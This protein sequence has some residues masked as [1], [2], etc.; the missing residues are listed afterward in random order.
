MNDFNII[1]AFYKNEL[2]EANEQKILARS[3][4][5]SN[6]QEIERLKKENEDLRKQLEEAQ[7]ISTDSEK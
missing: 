7:K 6:V 1:L 4:V 5:E 2:A 3:Q